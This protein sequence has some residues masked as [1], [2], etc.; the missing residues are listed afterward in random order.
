MKQKIYILLIL[1]L[2]S[3]GNSENQTAESEITSKNKLEIESILQSQNFKR[4]SLSSIIS[5]AIDYINSQEINNA[6]HSINKGDDSCGN[7]ML[8]NIWT[9]KE[10]YVRASLDII[11]IE[12]NFYDRKFECKNTV[13]YLSQ[14][15]YFILEKDTLYHQQDYILSVADS[16]M[17][18]VVLNGI[19]SLETYPMSEQKQKLLQKYV[20]NK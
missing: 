12:G 4:D 10:T 6:I 13:N 14:S 19:D 18:N 20:L 16:Q 1:L 5:L 7:G 3:C 8:K 15:E 17:I 9:F 2:S 11:I